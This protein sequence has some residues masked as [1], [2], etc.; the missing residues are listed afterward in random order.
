MPLT[1]DACVRLRRH[2]DNAILTE[3]PA[4]RVLAV[5]KP[6]PSTVYG[7]GL[8]VFVTDDT[9]YAHVV[10][11]PGVPG[12]ITGSEAT[13]YMAPAPGSVVRL[14]KMSRLPGDGNSPPVLVEQWDPVYEGED[15]PLVITQAASGTGF[16]GQEAV[17]WQTALENER[18]R[19]ILLENVLARIVERDLLPCHQGCVVPAFGLALEG[20]INIVS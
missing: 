3:K 10:L 19:R 2:A 18:R 1:T 9:S 20:L 12:N 6:E 17:A 14:L 13:D 16:G 11:A 4:V 8:M 15:M 5:V 7:A